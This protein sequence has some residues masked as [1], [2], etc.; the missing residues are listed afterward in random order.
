[1]DF[2]G[3]PFYKSDEVTGLRGEKFR[4]PDAEEAADAGAPHHE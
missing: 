1:M 3:T 4:D 2:R